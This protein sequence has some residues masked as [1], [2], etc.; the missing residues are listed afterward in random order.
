MQRSLKHLALALMAL[1]APLAL[2]A[3]PVFAQTGNLL[4]NGR[5]DLI[6]G[7]IGWQVISPQISSL[8]FDPALDADAC[9]G[10]GSASATADP[11]VDFGTASY[12]V[13]LGAVSPGQ[14]YWIAGEVLFPSSA[15][16]GRANLT[17]SFLTGP[18]CTVAY[19]PGGIFAGYAVSTAAGWQRVAAGPAIPDGTAQ[20]VMIDVMVTQIV[21]AE[22]AVSATFDEIRVTLTDGIFADDLELGESCRWSG[23]LP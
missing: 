2:L 11:S 21:G 8:S 18:N 20:S 12:R 1:I 3:A 5:F 22:P 6:D 14:I 23:I 7:I 15:I 16:A 10:S 13:C 9:S 4:P 17:L 19:A